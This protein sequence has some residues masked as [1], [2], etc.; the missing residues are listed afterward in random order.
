M[1]ISTSTTAP[2]STW[3]ATTVANQTYPHNA[4]RRD[5]ERAETF[6]LIIEEMIGSLDDLGMAGSA[7]LLRVKLAHA[8]ERFQTWPYTVK[9]AKPQ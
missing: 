9:R 3:W 1:G 8:E 2:T 7:Q 4:W 5:I 6:K